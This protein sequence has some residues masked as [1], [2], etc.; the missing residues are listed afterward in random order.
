MWDQMK[1]KVVWCHAALMMAGATFVQPSY[2]STL[3]FVLSGAE[4]ATFFLDSNPTPAG[5]NGTDYFYLVSVAG[6]SSGSP[7]TFP[8]LTFYSGPPSLF[9]G[10]LSAGTQQTDAGSNYFDAVGPQIFTGDVTAPVL[11]PGTF[12]L[13]QAATG[14]EEILTISE[15]PLPAALPL[16]AT[17]LGALG[18]LRWRRKRKA[19]VAI[20]A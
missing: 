10:G 4:S 13:H 18:F 1:L 19:S 7:V 15:T 3:S 6:M 12:L 8:F 16:F 5:G 20:A 9:G 14:A 2:A 11:S 17:G